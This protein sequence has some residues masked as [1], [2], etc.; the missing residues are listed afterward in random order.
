MLVG[1]PFE[2]HFD[3][4]IEFGG[5]VYVFYSNGRRQKGRQSSDAVFRRDPIVLRGNGAQLN[6]YF[7]FYLENNSNNSRA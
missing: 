6:K 1:A 5:A 7:S 4:D 2:Y 3:E